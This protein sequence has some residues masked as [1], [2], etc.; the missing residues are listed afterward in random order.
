M[1]GEISNYQVF[2]YLEVTKAKYETYQNICVSVSGGSDSDIMLD[3]FANLDKN[4][5]V[6]YVFFDTGFEYK[7]TKD[8][9]NYLEN[10]YQIKIDRVKAIKSIPLSCKEYGLPFLSKFI[11]QMIER[12]QKHNF[13]FKNDGN[14]SYEELSLIYKNL[15]CT[16]KWWCNR[17]G[18]NKIDVIDGRFNIQSKKYLKEFII[19]NP[20]NFKISSKCCKYAKKDTAKKY[21]KNVVIDLKCLGVRKAEGGIRATSYKSCFK[22]NDSKY[23]EFYPLFYWS[24]SDKDYYKD[25]FDITYSDCYEVWGLKRT[26][27]VGCPFDSKIFET[28]EKIKIYDNKMYNACL[29]VFGK[30]YDYKTKYLEFKKEMQLKGKNKTDK[31]QTDLFEKGEEN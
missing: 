1:I 27:C 8:H 12:L 9:L 28:L 5:K 10:K 24:D 22:V 3:M 16:L 18:K 26:G 19:E 21:E 17:T 2:K 15:D 11:S 29:K 6:K 23:D 20:P 4:K 13:D 7:A 30:S 14:K 31:N 25:Y